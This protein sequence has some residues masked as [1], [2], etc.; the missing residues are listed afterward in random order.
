[1]ANSKPKALERINHRT[2]VHQ[3]QQ[4]RAREQPAVN[5]LLSNTAELPRYSTR[6]RNYDASNVRRRFVRKDGCY[7]L[8]VPSSATPV[9]PR[10]F[11][12]A[13]Q[14]TKLYRSAMLCKL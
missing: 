9:C 10:I 6:S 4:L 14:T 11:T 1:M 5:F 7:L 8:S 13:Q 3:V 2:S 12:D